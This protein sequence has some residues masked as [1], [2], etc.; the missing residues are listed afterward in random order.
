MASLRLL[1]ISND[2]RGLDSGQAASTATAAAHALWLIVGF[3]EAPVLMV[4]SVLEARL[5]VRPE[6][7]PTGHLGKVNY[8]A[9]IELLDLCPF[10]RVERNSF[11]NPVAIA[12][13]ANHGA[14]AAT[15]AL[16]APLVPDRRLEL[17]VEEIWQVSYVDGCRETLHDAPANPEVILG[18]LRDDL[19]HIELIQDC[20]AAVGIYGYEISVAQIGKK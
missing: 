15:Q 18:V 16:A 11:G 12:G 5:S 6:V 3:Y 20:E 4:I 19:S 8:V 1:Q 2:F 7:V 13:W 14:G 9:G 10:L 17:D